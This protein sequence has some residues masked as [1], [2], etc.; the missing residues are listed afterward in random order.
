MVEPEVYIGLLKQT[1]NITK[2][3]LF[4]AKSLFQKPQVIQ[5]IGVICAGIAQ[6]QA[7]LN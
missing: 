5:S 6:Q 2:Q 7:Y 4:Y 1:S 3:L